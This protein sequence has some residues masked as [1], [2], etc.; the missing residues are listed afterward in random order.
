MSE[1][2]ISGWILSGEDLELISGYIAIENGII[3][4]V[5]EEKV[6]ADFLVIPS[7]INAHVHTGDAIAKDIEFEDLMD[8][9]RPP[10]GLKHRILRESPRER[11]VEAMRRACEDMKRCGIAAFCD[12][13]EGGVEGV[14]MIRE[15]SSEVLPVILG[16]PDGC[17]AEDVLE[18]SDGIGASGYLDVPR[19]SLEEWR[20]RARRAGK[21]FAIHAGE[22]SRDDIEGAL[23]LEP[24]FVVHMTRAE[25]EDLKKMRD[26]EIP[27]VVCPRANLD[28]AGICGRFP[29]LREMLEEGICVAAGTDNLMI[30]GVD[31]FREMDF[32]SRVYRIPPEEILKMFT[33]N[34]AR[35]LGREDEIGWIEKGKKAYITVI[36]LNSSNTCGTKNVLR[37]LVRRV[38][39]DDI[40]K[41]ISGV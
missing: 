22:F 15:A 17:T 10:D 32:I 11:I 31:L 8:V 1:T 9:V 13:R 5:E 39:V 41:T 33:V 37:T 25:R 34:S 29:P 7:L 30:N 16:R 21:L 19:S 35:I 26:L 36:N 18:I 6:R 23:S 24:D 2:I 20:E 3:K 38:R 40:V 4:E 12:F 27:A 14:K 28:G